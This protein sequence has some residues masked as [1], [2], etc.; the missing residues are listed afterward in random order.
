MAPV[1]DASS[2][3]KAQMQLWS[4]LDASWARTSSLFFLIPCSTYSIPFVLF[5]LEGVGVIF[6]FLETRSYL[7]FG[8]LLCCL[9]RVWSARE[10][11]GDDNNVRSTESRLWRQVACINCNCE[12]TESFSRLIC[13][14]HDN[15]VLRCTLFNDE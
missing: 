12:R 8:L 13:I 7:L 4:C 3:L 5:F 10:Y 6:L 11:A 9:M 2:K 14:P 15:S 1:F